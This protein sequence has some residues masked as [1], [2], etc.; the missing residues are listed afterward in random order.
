[1]SSFRFKLRELYISM[2]TNKKL[3]KM[4]KKQI[5]LSG[6][7][8]VTIALLLAAPSCKKDDDNNGTSKHFS[9]SFQDGYLDDYGWVVLHNPDG[10]EV[11]DY[12]KIEGDGTAD[13]GEI[14]G[15]IIS[16]TIIRVDTINYGNGYTGTYIYLY[17]Y[18]ASPC[19]NWK[20]K[21]GSYSDDP[22]GTADITMTYPEDNYNEYFLNT[23]STGHNSEQVPPG[24]LNQQYNVYYL[25]EGNKY[26][27][28]GAVMQGNGG[29]C[30]W[31]LN[32]NFQLYQTNYYSFE[33][34]KTLSQVNVTTSKPLDYFYLN[35]FYNDRNSDL[36]LYRKSYYNTTSGEETNHTVYVPE[37]MPVSHLLFNGSYSGDN[38]SYNYRK[39][40]DMQQGLP[41]NIEIP[42]QTI[43]ATYNESTDEIY[44]IQVNG[45]ADQV[46][47]NW[48]FWDNSGSNAFSISWYVYANWDYP[49]L[50]RPVLPQ[51]IR[52]EIGE[53]IY[54]LECYRIVLNDF[55][56]TSNL[57][58]IVNY[59]FI[60]E[61]PTS[62]RYDESFSYYYYFDQYKSRD[63]NQRKE[64][65]NDPRIQN[66]R[67]SNFYN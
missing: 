67:H 1:M 7:L 51:E 10:T 6:I 34:N 40:F 11:I 3:N 54:L 2:L 41:G 4:Q 55:N 27:L 44:N 16:T 52:D 65:H 37:N 33:L 9:M 60:N 58:D 15:G 26:S 31:L 20:F 5:L 23:T 36:R 64:E 61:V 8:A 48:G 25:D 66:N 49:S 14:N 13:F 46:S 17:S 45:T 32:Q 35:G 62:Q 30:N 28:Y 43:S 39:F 24:G 57:A 12:K 18:F 56:T 53:E 63:F 29:W 19:G 59:F 38:T 21:G 47:G 42:H 22:L 50:Q